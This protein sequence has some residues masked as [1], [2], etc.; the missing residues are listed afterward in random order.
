[1]EVIIDGVRYAPVEE[2]KRVGDVIKFS[3]L[4]WFIIDQDEDSYTL[5][6]KECMTPELVKRHFTQRGMVDDDYDIRYSFTNNNAWEESYIRLVLNTSFVYDL[7]QDNLIEMNDDYVRLI[8]KDE[9]EKLPDKIKKV[10]RKY[11]YWSMTPYSAN[12]NHAFIVNTHGTIFGNYDVTNTF[13]AR[14]VIKIRRSA[15]DE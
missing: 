4:D 3:N 10:N 11:G 13:A 12:T 5:F 14:P 15:I 6:M 8:T 9:I 1:M 2:D 7:D